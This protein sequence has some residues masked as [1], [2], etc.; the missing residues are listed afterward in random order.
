MA[1]YTQRCTG[2]CGSVGCSVVINSI[3][4]VLRP[5]QAHVCY[6][7]CAFWELCNTVRI[8]VTLQRVSASEDNNYLLLCVNFY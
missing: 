6:P 3:R 4:G 8:F 7:V 1:D 2:V 5:I